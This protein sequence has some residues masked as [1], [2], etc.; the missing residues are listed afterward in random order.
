MSANRCGNT[1]GH[2]REVLG[3]Y[4]RRF[5]DNESVSLVIFENIMQLPPKREWGE[6]PSNKIG[7][8]IRD[9][10]LLA[11]TALRRLIDRNSGDGIA[12]AE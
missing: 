11:N 7:C 9:N 1:C 10:E 2:I 3:A 6:Q 8:Q 5:L 4:R 12:Y